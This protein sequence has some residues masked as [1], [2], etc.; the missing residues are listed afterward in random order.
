MFVTILPCEKCLSK[1]A[2][3]L[4]TL[5]CLPQTVS[6]CFFALHLPRKTDDVFFFYAPFQHTCGCVQGSMWRHFGAALPAQFWCFAP[7]PLGRQ[8]KRVLVPSKGAKKKR[9][10]K[11]RCCMCVCA[12]NGKTS[13]E[14][15]TAVGDRSLLSG[16]VQCIFP[17]TIY[18]LT[19]FQ[20][21]NYFCNASKTVYVHNHCGLHCF[22]LCKPPNASKD[23]IVQ[24]SRWTRLAK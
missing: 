21:I 24:Y 6:Q 22:L 20:Q 11:E 3:F 5:R 2:C 16:E 9:L 7:L 18:H 19:A 8:N 13:G 4:S 17:S 12:G 23:S 14:V 1:V 15:I 10:V